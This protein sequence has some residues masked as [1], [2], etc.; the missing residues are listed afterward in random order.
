MSSR[1]PDRIT[2]KYIAAGQDSAGHPNGTVTVYRDCWGQVMTG[3]GR[4]AERGQQ[5]EHVGTVR[6]KI[7]RPRQGRFPV[8]EDSATFTQFGRER[9]LDLVHVQDLD[10]KYILLHCK[11]AG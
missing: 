1:L 8:V 11:E 2:L 10:D 4:E 7:M 6:I 9:T 3:A 5:M